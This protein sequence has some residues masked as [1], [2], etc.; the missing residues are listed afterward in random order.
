M[1]VID[2]NSMPPK[3]IGRKV[4]LQ[5]KSLLGLSKDLG[6]KRRPNT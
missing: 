5:A 6:A 3:V 4:Y 2:M 1:V